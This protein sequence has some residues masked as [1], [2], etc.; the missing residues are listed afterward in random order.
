M[1]GQDVLFGDFSDGF[2]ELEDGMEYN[3][4]SYCLHAEF[5][6]KSLVILNSRIIKYLCFKP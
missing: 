4:V 6:A 2:T 1:K 5:L 3:K